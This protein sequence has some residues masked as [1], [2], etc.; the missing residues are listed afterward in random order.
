MRVLKRKSAPKYL[1][2]DQER[3]AQLNSLKLYRLLKSDINLIMADEKYF[4]L[5]GNMA[6]NRSY[7]TCDPSNT[8]P[9]IKF[10]RRMKFEPK[11][12]VWWAVSAKGRSSVYAH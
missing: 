10:K 12:L 2:E 3:R 9:E 11:L 4:T 7:Y 5:T 6:G 1:N 8:P